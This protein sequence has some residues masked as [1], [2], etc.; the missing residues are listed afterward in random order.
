MESYS[1]YEIRKK[2]VYKNKRKKRSPNDMIESLRDFLRKAPEEMTD[3]LMWYV[4]DASIEENRKLLQYILNDDFSE[5]YKDSTMINESI[6]LLA[7]IVDS[8][9]MK[10]FWKEV[11]HNIFKI[12]IFNMM[13]L[14]LTVAQTL[15]IQNAIANKDSD[16][17]AYNIEKGGNITAI[18][19]LKY[20]GRALI[21]NWNLDHIYIS[22]GTCEI[23]EG[24]H[25]KFGEIKR[26][27]DVQEIKEEFDIDIF[28]E[29]VIFNRVSVYMLRFA[30]IT[31][32]YT[33]VGTIICRL[34]C[35]CVAVYG[36]NGN[37]C[38][39]EDYDDNYD[40]YDIYK[41]SLD[42]SKAPS[43]IRMI[44]SYKGGYTRNNLT[45]D[46]YDLEMRLNTKYI[47]QLLLIAYT[48]SENFN[49]HKVKLF[50][51]N[52]KSFV[53]NTV[54]DDVEDISDIKFN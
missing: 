49:A 27:I 31:S 53:K 48:S 39:A 34:A 1:V 7:L 10:E 9:K 24:A 54:F 20:Y 40:N 41:H 47:I 44:Y 6:F 28:M 50:V 23:K 13:C 33:D 17:A 19:A 8:V 12:I 25:V 43:S 18:D 5:A 30:T 16:I 22:A 38:I 36:Y 14:S 4:A 29:D 2:Y 35:G 32:L 45:K 42:V 3:I 37:I 46:L 15:D 52:I 21:E 26:K 11:D 51:D